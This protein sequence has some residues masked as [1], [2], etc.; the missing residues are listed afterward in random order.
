[1]K[2]SIDKK[3]ARFYLWLGVG[4]FFI[5]FLNT[6]TKHPD[7]FLPSVFNNLWAIIYLI[8][9]N[10]IF[11][12]YTVP[13]VL[14][15]R[16]IIIY[17]ILLGI[18]L[19]WVHMLLWSYGLYVWRSLGIQLHVYTALTD[20]PSL[21]HLLENLMA[22]SAGSVFFFGIIRHIYNYIKLKQTQQQ[23]RIEQP[24]GYC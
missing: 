24:A 4:Y 23:L 9:I 1:M 8:L 14:R 12:E 6:I 15:K 2:I 19:L 16:K 7:R 20:F 17:N 10:F 11:F 21:D 5:G 3:L 18:F 13:F 22:Y